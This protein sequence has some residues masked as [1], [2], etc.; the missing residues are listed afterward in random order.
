MVVAEFLGGNNNNGENSVVLRE[1][2][3]QKLGSV[4][5]N[6]DQKISVNDSIRNT[7]DNYKKSVTKRRSIAALSPQLVEVFILPNKVNVFIP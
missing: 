2:I 6:F 7:K 3:L 1:A 5:D 4:T